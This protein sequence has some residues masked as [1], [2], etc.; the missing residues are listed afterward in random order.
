MTD[1]GQVA[2][3]VAFSRVSNSL[4]TSRLS[5]L[6][7]SVL[8]LFLKMT[9]RAV[10]MIKELENGSCINV[11][12]HFVKVLHIIAHFKVIPSGINTHS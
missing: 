5:N 1:D 10:A 8:N 12:F 4:D 3:A 2:E 9:H 7:D 11:Q 6:A